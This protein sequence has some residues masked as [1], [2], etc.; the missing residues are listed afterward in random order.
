MHEK[1]IE[2]TK[3]YANYIIENQFNNKL[4]IDELLE[5]MKLYL[6]EK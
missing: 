2:P 4:N 3:I 1:F 6:N 5:K